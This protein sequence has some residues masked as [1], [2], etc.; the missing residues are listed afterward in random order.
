MRNE[1][2]IDARIQKEI[3]IFS[4][5]ATFNAAIRTGTFALI[6]GSEKNRHTYIKVIYAGEID[7]TLKNTLVDFNLVRIY[8]K[9]DSEQYKAKS[10]KT[11]FNKIIRADRIIPLKYNRST[12]TYEEFYE[13]HTEEK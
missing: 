6:D 4:E 10:G 11:V 2:V 8:G 13:E 9:I 7:D 3:H 12:G 1:I 5:L